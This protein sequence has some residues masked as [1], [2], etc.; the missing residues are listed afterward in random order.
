MLNIYSRQPLEASPLYGAIWG[1]FVFT[2]LAKNEFK[3]GNNLF[4]F[5]D[6]N[7]VEIDFVIEKNAKTWLIEARNDERPNKSKLNFR[8]IA[9]LFKVRID[10]VVA[11]RTRESSNY[12]LKDYTLSNPLFDLNLLK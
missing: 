5:R 6:Q 7:G 1:N 3:V 12:R 9:P 11:C 2:E 8:K 10:C 4:Y